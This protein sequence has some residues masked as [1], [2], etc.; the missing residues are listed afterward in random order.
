MGFIERLGYGVDRV[1]DLMREKHLREPKFEETAGGFRVC[2]YN[3][4]LGEQ[5]A[6]DKAAISALK[7]DGQYQG[8]MV[9]PRQEAALIYLLRDGNSRITNSDLQTLC[10]DVHPETIRRDLADLVTKDIL[11]ELGEKRGSYY[12]MNND[13][14]SQTV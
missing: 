11:R 10:P 1:I 8:K 6:T 5:P 13:P 12:V 3:D 4:P 9:N 7:I 14:L 2:L